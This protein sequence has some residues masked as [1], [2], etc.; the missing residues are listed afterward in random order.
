VGTPKKKKKGFF[1]NSD[2]NKQTFD[3]TGTKILRRRNGEG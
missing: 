1:F 3:H 2:K